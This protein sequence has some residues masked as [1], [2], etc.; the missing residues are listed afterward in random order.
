[1][2]HSGLNKKKTVIEMF[3]FQSG[4]FSVNGQTKD[5]HSAISSAKTAPYFFT[6]KMTEYDLDKIL[7]TKW[8]LYSTEHC[9]LKWDSLACKGIEIIFTLRS[10]TEY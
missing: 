8:F 9:F 10:W 1:M 7:S 3:F 6:L 5:Q 2:Q 4:C